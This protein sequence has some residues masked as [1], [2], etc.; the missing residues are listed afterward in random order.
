MR[1]LRHALTAMA[2]AGL[3]LAAVS[4][5]AAEDPPALLPPSPPS[6]FVLFT[7]EA[8]AAQYE[9]T[10]LLQDFE[11]GAWTTERRHDGMAFF[12]VLEGAVT[13]RKAGKDT[14]YAKGPVL[15]R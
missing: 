9:E 8:P 5:A 7:V 14:L 2:M 6:H 10:L 1:A 13:M 11:P 12:S 15:P 3:A 4:S